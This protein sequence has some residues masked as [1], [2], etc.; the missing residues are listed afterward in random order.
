MSG[1]KIIM[2]P[3]HD[4]PSVRLCGWYG[5][6]H[7]ESQRRSDENRGGHQPIYAKRTGLSD[8]KITELLEWKTWMLADKAVELGFADEVCP[9]HQRSKAR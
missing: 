3:G 7:G 9:R 4:S 5:G 8:E 6:R 2:S 1:D